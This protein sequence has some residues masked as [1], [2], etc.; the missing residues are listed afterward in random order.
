MPAWRAP[1]IPPKIGIV[2][3]RDPRRAVRRLRTIGIL[4]IAAGISAASLTYWLETR[5]ATPS[6]EDLLPGSRAAAA[7]QNG[8]L[9]GRG[10]ESLIEVFHDLKEP[11]GQAILIVLASVVG[12]ATCFR[13]AWIREH[14]DI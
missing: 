6:I 10:V 4:V 3:R 12:A 1:W 5:R 13:A 7:R 2:P 11:G 9:Y 8:L 14:G